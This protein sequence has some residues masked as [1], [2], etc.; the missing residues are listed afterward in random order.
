[1]LTLSDGSWTKSCAGVSRR[2]FLRIGSLA[3]GAATGTFG[4]NEL[5]LRRALAREARA[6]L[7][8]RAVVVLFLQGGPSHIEMFDPKM[9]APSDVRST[10]GEVRTKLPG[11]TFA[12]TFPKLAQRAD[13]LAVVRSYGTRNTAHTYGEVIS[14][15]N[16]LKASMG[17]LYA[18]AAGLNHPETGMPTYTLVTPEAIRGDLKL[19]R[20]FE[21]QAL[22]TL[23]AP[24]TLGRAYD[25]FNPVG[26]GEFQKSLELRVPRD[27]LLDRKVLLDQL[28]RLR[29]DLETD[30]SVALSGSYQ[31]RAYDMVLRGIGEAFDLSKEDPRT[32]SRYDTTK[33]FRMED[34][35]RYNDMFRTTNLLGHQMLLARRLCEAGCGFVTVTDSGWDMH[36]NR[37]SVAGMTGM[38]PMGHQV[39]HAVAAFLDDVE[40][41]GLSDKILLVVTGE[42]GRTPKINR[43]GGRDHY[44]NLTSL[45]VAGG[46]LNMG[47]VIGRSDAFAADADS[48][49][50]G[51]KNLLA[52]VAHSVFDIGELRVAREVPQG[53]IDV[54]TADEPISELL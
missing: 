48:R 21:T 32:L 8:D 15:R 37:N 29:R 18:R 41:R 30:P 22:P 46:G 52:T 16:P 31:E 7:R 34:L 42:M 54:L 12:G 19:R 20:N 50:Y 26:N 28:D 24:G 13:R 2:S 27:R 9:D 3:F 40:E 1:M 36:G 5:L 44:G 23:T 14:A 53:V 4:L 51:P 17:S 10:T 11:I 45:L 33:L 6:H 35:N 49:P 25:A 38:V 43:G 39:D 47:Q